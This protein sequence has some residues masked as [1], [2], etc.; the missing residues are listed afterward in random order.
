MKF[1]KFLNLTDHTSFS[2]FILVF[3]SFLMSGLLTGCVKNEVQLSFD[4]PGVTQETLRLSYYASD[5]KKGW[6]TEEYVNVQQG[7][8]TATLRTVNPTLV[9][10]SPTSG[11]APVVVFY[12]ERGDEIAISGSGNDP[13]FYKISGNDITD[14]LTAWRLSATKALATALSDPVAGAAEVNKLVTGYVKKNPENPASML[15]LLC[16]YDRRADEKG[17]AQTR[18][19]LKGEALEP[20]WSQLVSRADMVDDTTPAPKLPASILLNT[21]NGCDTLHTGR[22]PALLYFHASKPDDEVLKSLRK[23]SDEY[24]DSASRIISDISFEPDSSNRVFTMRND[25]LRKVVR[26]W[27]PLGTSDS[28]AHQLG[29]RRVPYLIV[30]DRKGTVRYRGDDMKQAEAT[31]RSLLKK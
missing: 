18:K 22:Q 15:L 8:A 25:S 3:A 14:D 24:G 4:L 12:A 29:V 30:S 1:P 7:K 2:F 6:L 27:M 10:L 21:G 28:T 23:M 26:A 5:S 20:V 13:L 31:F 9:F 16:Y 11:N 17:F 19:L